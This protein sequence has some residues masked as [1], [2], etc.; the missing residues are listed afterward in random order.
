MSAYAIGHLEKIDMG[1]G[2]MQYLQGIDATLAPFGGSF[3]IHGDGIE[4]MEG[5][6]E[7][8]I[9]VIQFPDIECAR[10]WYVS[11]AYRAIL[12]L[13]TDNSKSIVFLVPGVSANH[14][15]TDVLRYTYWGTLIT[16]L[17]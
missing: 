2:I 17:A 10:Q 12:P 7:G 1:I 6:L 14:K 3:I 9:I 4:L 5:T 16:P 8:D 15:A 11:P 13:R